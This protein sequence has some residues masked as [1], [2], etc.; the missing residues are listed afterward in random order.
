MCKA[1]PPPHRPGAPCEV[2]GSCELEDCFPTEHLEQGSSASTH[3]I[4]RVQKYLGPLGKVQEQ[5]GGVNQG[6]AYDS[7]PS[8]QESTEPIPPQSTG[9]LLG[10]PVASFGVSYLKV[11]INE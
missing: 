1:T 4:S 9:F 6:G 11:E 7:A 8:S 5:V 10:V 2:E 3:P